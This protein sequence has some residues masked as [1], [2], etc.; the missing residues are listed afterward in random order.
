MSGPAWADGIRAGDRVIID[1]RPQVVL[2]AS[3]TAIRFA[4]DDGAVEEA[5][6]A[7]LT[8]SG[9]LQLRPVGGRPG[10]QVGMA[11]LPPEVVERAR[12]WEAH[13]IEVVGG[14]RP[15]VPAGTP[16][17][18]EYDVQRTSL[19]ELEQ[20][21][22]AE[23]STPGKPVSA[24]TVKHRRQ[25]WQAEGLP[26]LVDR[27]VTQ[28]RSPAGRADPAVTGRW[29]R[30]LPRRP[31]IGQGR[32]R[33]SSGAPGRSWPSGARP[34][35][36]RRGPPCS[37]CSPGCRRAATRPGPRSPAEAWRGGRSGCFRRLT[38]PRRAS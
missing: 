35:R 33:S 24:S 8:G 11:G 7:E 26:G 14:T 20:A 12:W 13:F 36:S 21:K 9:R 31:T 2:G 16:P 1:G 38:R 19:R 10:P 37:G 29:G 15:D 3:G 25:H 34:A 5:A 23:L 6:V 27:R 28:R 4:G 18:P 22:A 30:R 32:R 17:R